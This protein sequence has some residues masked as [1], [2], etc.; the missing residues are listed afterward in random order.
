[1]SFNSATFYLNIVCKALK[2]P[3]L[4]PLDFNNQKKPAIDHEALVE[5]VG[6]GDGL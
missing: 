3:G 1:M 2:D 6:L 5:K 4:C